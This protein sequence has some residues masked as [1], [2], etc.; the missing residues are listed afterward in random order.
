MK[1]GKEKLVQSSSLKTIILSGEIKGLKSLPSEENL[2][3]GDRLFWKGSKRLS[4]CQKKASPGLRDAHRRRE[5][6]LRLKF[7][8]GF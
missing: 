4:K 1:G 8:R 6:L 3:V 5:H 2:T 7:P